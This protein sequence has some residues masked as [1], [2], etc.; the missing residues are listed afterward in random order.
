MILDAKA[1][2]TLLAEASKAD[3]DIAGY[4]TEQLKQVE[5]T[6]NAIVTLKAR[7][8]REMN[9]HAKRVDRINRDIAEVRKQCKHRQT[10]YHPDPSGGRDSSRTCDVCGAEL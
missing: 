7:L 5:Y 4:V 8:H 2:S 10:T 6:E 3:C 9:E 1:M